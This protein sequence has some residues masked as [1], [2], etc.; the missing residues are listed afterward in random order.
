M[1]HAGGGVKVMT[2]NQNDLSKV[3]NAKKAIPPLAKVLWFYIE[4]FI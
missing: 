1:P 4:N 3:K 2:K